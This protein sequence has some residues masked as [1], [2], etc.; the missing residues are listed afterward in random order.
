[1]SGK[2][3]ISRY[4]RRV[5]QE[6]YL[7]QKRRFEFSDRRDIHAVK[8]TLWDK[9]HADGDADAEVDVTYLATRATGALS[10]AGRSATPRHHDDC[11][12]NEAFS[13][14]PEADIQKE[15]RKT[16]GTTPVL[17]SDSEREQWEGQPGSSDT[18][19]DEWDLVAS[20]SDSE[21]EDSEWEK[22]TEE[23]YPGPPKRSYAA[24]LRAHQ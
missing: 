14:K 9:K 10:I 3:R 23:F 2:L 19:R 15:S 13:E 6:A 5:V 18:Q 21:A 17:A 7:A 11:S 20:D 16:P 8:V 12:M 4:P 22:V 24:V 1:M